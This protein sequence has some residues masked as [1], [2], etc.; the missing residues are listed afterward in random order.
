MTFVISNYNPGP[1]RAPRVFVNRPFTFQD[2]HFFAVHMVT[3]V[4]IQSR[5][6][7]DAF[8]VSEIPLTLASATLRESTTT[9][10]TGPEELLFFELKNWCTR[11]VQDPEAIGEPLQALAESSIRWKDFNR[12]DSSMRIFN[13]QK[14]IKLLPHSVFVKACEEFGFPLMKSL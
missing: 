12:W 10:P 13:V 14:N 3:V 9:S 2:A 4:V 8:H 11:H 5:Q 6:V 1:W 7:G